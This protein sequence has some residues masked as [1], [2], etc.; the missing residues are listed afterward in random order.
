MSTL[1]TRDDGGR[2]PS[3][4]TMCEVG[5]TRCS[6]QHWPWR[7]TLA[8]NP[9]PTA[10][11]VPPQKRCGTGAARP[12]RELFAPA[13]N[14]TVSRCTSY[15]AT[16]ESAPSVASTLPGNQRL[17]GCERGRQ[18]SA[19]SASKS[20]SAM[21]GRSFVSRA[22]EPRTAERNRHHAL[23][24]RGPVGIDNV[25]G[26]LSGARIGSERSVADAPGTAA[27]A[28]LR[29]KRERGGAHHAAADGGQAH[30][31]HRALLRLMAVRD[32]R[33]AGRDLARRGTTGQ[34]V[35][36]AVVAGT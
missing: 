7:S 15:S 35:E 25:G 9:V 36:G 12:G 27:R 33:L 10:S 14:A 34:R 1:L 26:A 4:R 29:S 16:D 18:A 28:V 30:R 5:A 23:Q 8:S 31:R 32:G 3:R 6:S 19:E 17:R 24:A 2:T 22:R 11:A 21:I 20:N 13:C